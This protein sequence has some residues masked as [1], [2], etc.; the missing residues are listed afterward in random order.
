MLGILIAALVAGIITALVTP[1]VRRWVEARGVVDEPGE[2]RENKETKPRAGGIAIYL[3]FVIAV[4]V[5]V[6]IRQFARDGQHTWSM[7]VVGILLATTFAAVTGLVDDFK[8]LSAVKQVIAIL[9][10]G[11]ILVAFNVRIEGVSNLLGMGQS[12]KYVASQHWHALNNI[13]SILATLIWVFVVTKTVDAID[14]LDGLAS[15]VCAISATALA[16]MAVQMAR[17]EFATLAVIAA[18]L[19]GS[20]LGFLRHNAYPSKIIMGTIGAWTLGVPLAAVSILGAFKVAAAVSFVVPIL[21]LGVPIFDYIHVVARRLLDHAPLT[22][23]DRR[24]LHHRLMDR[25]GHDQRKVV[26]FIYGVAIVF[27]VVALCVFQFTRV[28][29]RLN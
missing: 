20:C 19:A 5:A 25:W 3:G 22:S 6:T 24:H 29:H 12:G 10:A 17:P 27:C 26:Y 8:D 4:I 13:T 23:A 15:G 9:G 21:V 16:L 14:G 28:P 2:R 11:L 7:Q 18:A 1:S